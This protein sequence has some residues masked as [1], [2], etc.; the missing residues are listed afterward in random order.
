MRNWTHTL[1]CG[2][3]MGQASTVGQNCSTNSS[4]QS[5]VWGNL[6]S[7]DGG[8]RRK[9]A[10]N[11]EQDDGCSGSCLSFRCLVPNPFLRTS[12]WVE[13]RFCR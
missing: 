8:E 2:S 11:G 1:S 9:V 12:P 4:A 13:P 7:Y 6:A 5:K 3:N 10:A